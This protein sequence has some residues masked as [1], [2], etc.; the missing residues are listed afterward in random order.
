MPPGEDERASREELQERPRLGSISSS[1]LWGTEALLVSRG[2]AGFNKLVVIKRL[3]T[4]LA[5]DRDFRRMFFDEARLAARLN[6]PNVVQ[7]YEVG[8]SHLI[9]MEYLDGQPLH[10]VTREAVRV[11]EPLGPFVSA[12]IVAD[13]L[14][15]LHSAHELRDYEGLPLGIIH[16]DV[17]PHNIF[18]TYDGQE[19]REDSYPASVN[20][21]AGLE[22]HAPQRVDYG[23]S[24][25][26]CVL[27]RLAPSWS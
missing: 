23:L 25:A 2:P 6:H 21:L 4:A 3:R 8:G 13:A 15:G 7:T 1:R 9:A 16:R 17:S 11:G 19:H 10:K 20:E 5:E 14:S 26:L 12:R 22:T 18:V 24:H 27:D